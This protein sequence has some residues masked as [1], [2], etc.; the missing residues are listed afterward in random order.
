MWNSLR[1]FKL[2]ICL[3]I[4][5]RTAD[6]CELVI[7]HEATN[8]L[9]ISL[10]VI[11]SAVGDLVGYFETYKKFGD[12]L[13]LVNIAANAFSG[14]LSINYVMDIDERVFLNVV[15]HGNS[16][17][18]RSKSYD[19]TQSTSGK[20]TEVV[21]IDWQHSVRCAQRMSLVFSS[22]TDVL[23]CR[24]DFN[25]AK[26]PATARSCPLLVRWININRFQCGQRR[27]GHLHRSAMNHQ[28]RQ[29]PL[30]HQ[31]QTV[32]LRQRLIRLQQRATLW[33]QSAQLQRCTKLRQ[34]RTQ[35]H[36]PRRPLQILRSTLSLRHSSNGK[37]SV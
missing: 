35:Q 3:L 34:S 13:E 7:L 18:Y 1:C 23:F 27:I 31:Q 25:W 4:V 33:Q 10:H 9:Q 36:H 24:F 30:N 12:C 32:R 20:I 37:S 22:I 16:T 17:G 19:L 21:D 26:A 14:T 29:Q 8:A 2:F 15:Y 5:Y 6:A 28:L 11:P